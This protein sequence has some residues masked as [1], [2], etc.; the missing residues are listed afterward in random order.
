[1][2]YAHWWACYPTAPAY[3]HAWPQILHDSLR[4]I[5]RAVASGINICGPHGYC[6]PVIDR[7]AGIRIGGDAAHGR[8]QQPLLLPPPPRHPCPSPDGTRQA[9]TGSVDTARHPYDSVAAA[10]LLRTHQ[11][12]GHHHFA[13][14][15]D[16]DWNNE[17]AY[18]AR[19]GYLPART[20]VTD[21]FGPMP[22]ISPL[23]WPPQPHPPCEGNPTH[24]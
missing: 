24:A 7:Y 15:S 13:I 19:T 9:T 2:R 6:A 12:L 22:D 4:I 5:T 23:T 16:G 3:A 8:H 17:W 21:L 14:R 1:M 20:L 10:I 18:G 11:L